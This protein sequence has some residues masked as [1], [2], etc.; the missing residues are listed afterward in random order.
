MEEEIIKNGYQP[1]PPV[2][3]KGNPI[4]IELVPPKGEVSIQ[5][6]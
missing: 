5:D 1:K 4:E 3:E 6:F 2:D